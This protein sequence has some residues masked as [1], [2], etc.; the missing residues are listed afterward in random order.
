MRASLHIVQKP[1]VVLLIHPAAQTQHR[2]SVEQHQQM[3]PHGGDGGIDDDLAEVADEQID[4]VGQKQ[5]LHRVAVM[6]DGVE[7]GGHIHQQ[8]GEDAPQILDIP[9][10]HEQR[11]QDQPHAYVEQRQTKDGVEQQDKAPGE[12]DA[13]QHAEQEKDAQR[14]GKVDQRLDV[15]GEQEQVFRHV[16]LGENGGVACQRGHALTGGFV[17]VGKHQVAAEQVGGIVL[18]AP[19]KELGEHQTH[20]QQ[21]QQRRQHAPRHAQHGAFIFLLEV[22]LH[23]LFK[24]KAVL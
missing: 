22:A 14:Q 19:A 2:R 20:H 1:G 12:D 8:L 5:A 23:Q 3:E 6:V 17:E 18:H 13:V 9:E 11:R 7:N 10:E 16:D 15:F 4:G 24:K 21:H